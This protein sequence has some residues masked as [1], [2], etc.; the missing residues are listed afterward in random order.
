M[1]CWVCLFHIVNG[2]V[3]WSADVNS[4]RQTDRKKYSSRWI[5]VASNEKRGPTEVNLIWDPYP[6]LENIDCHLNG[7]EK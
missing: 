4:L 7:I 5:K 3:Y 2:G 6:A 1:A